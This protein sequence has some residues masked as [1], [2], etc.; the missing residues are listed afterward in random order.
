MSDKKVLLICTS[1]TTFNNGPSGA[2]LEE[3]A[4]SYY[5]FVAAGIAVDFA[6]PAGGAIPID[7][8]SMGDGFFT[9]VAKKAMHDPV[10]VGGFSHS[11]KLADVR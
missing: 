4:A 3:M 8:G 2:W 7:A 5:K 9:D 1:S 6:S 10:F 11:H